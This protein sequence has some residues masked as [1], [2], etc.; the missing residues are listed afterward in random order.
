[1]EP[2]FMRI[3]ARKEKLPQEIRTINWFPLAPMEITA[4][5]K[6][7]AGIFSHGTLSLTVI[8][9]ETKRNHI[10]C[11]SVARKIGSQYKYVQ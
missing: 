11:E 7:A 6:V 3:I 4:R 10:L 8:S 2:H 5:N 1:M 9:R